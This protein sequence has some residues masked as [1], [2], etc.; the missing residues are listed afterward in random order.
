MCDTEGS[1]EHGDR[2]S[3]ELYTLAGGGANGDLS[4]LAPKVRKKVD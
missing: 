1:Q 2:T 3:G 4:F